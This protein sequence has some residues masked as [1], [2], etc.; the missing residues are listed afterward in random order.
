MLTMSDV[1]SSRSIGMA[2]AAGNRLHVRVDDAQPERGGA[3]RDRPPD[4]AVADDAE[5]SC[6]AARAEHEVER[7]PLPAAASDQP[8]AFATRAA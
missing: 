8:I 1:A 6:R 4:A 3:R 2:L 5:L 7:P